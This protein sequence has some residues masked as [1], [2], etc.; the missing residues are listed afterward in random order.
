MSLSDD[1]NRYDGDDGHCMFCKRTIHQPIIKPGMRADDYM[2]MLNN[3]SADKGCMAASQKYTKYF[4]WVLLS[5]NLVQKIVDVLDKLVES[6]D[7][8]IEV[9]AGA[10][11][12]SYFIN[13]LLRRSGS[14]ITVVPSDT[15]AKGE[16]GSWFQHDHSYAP[17]DILHVDALE[18]V[19]QAKPKVLMMSYPNR[20]SNIAC[21]VVKRFVDLGGHKLIYYGEMKEGMCA[22]DNFFDYLNLFE[23][24]EIIPYEELDNWFG[25]HSSCMLFDFNKP[26]FNASI[27]IDP[28]SLKN[29]TLNNWLN[30]CCDE[31]KLK[32]AFNHNFENFEELTSY[33]SKDR[34]Q[35]PSY[36]IKELING[37]SIA[38]DLDVK[39]ITHSI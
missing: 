9:F 5:W 14:G 12:L 1:E 21:E 34:Y 7:P 18:H 29:D 33:I 35:T 38:L 2:L 20:N 28:R 26:R 31:L 13:S 36:E 10:G 4:S 8:V 25:F 22:N 15:A 37:I 24:T 6:E 19:Q 17:I 27:V 11:W 32:N 30:M 3:I 16:Y 23:A 39:S